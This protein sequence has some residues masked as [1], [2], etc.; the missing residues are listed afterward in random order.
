ME[1][2]YSIYFKILF[3]FSATRNIYFRLKKTAH[4]TVSYQKQKTKFAQKK[5]KVVL[6]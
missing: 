6:V 4:D 5:D 3:F 2:K 1:S